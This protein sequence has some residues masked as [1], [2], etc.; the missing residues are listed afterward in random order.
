MK[1]TV[2]TLFL[3]AA[4]A[5]AFAQVQVDKPVL[6]EGATAADRRVIGLSN[7]VDEDDAL[8]ART[9]QAGGYR[10][11]EAV[12]SD[13]W[14]VQLDPPPSALT[15]GLKLLVKASVEN[16]GPVTIDVNSLGAHAVLK[17]GTAPLEAGDVLAGEV[18]TLVFDGTVFQLLGARRLERRPCPSGF[19]Q[20]NELYCIEQVERDSLTFY[21]ASLLCTGMNARLCSWGEW[22]AAC[23]DAASLGLTGMTG[24]W[25][26]TNDAANADYYVRVVG[27]FSCPHSGIAYGYSEERNYRCC[28]RR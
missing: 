8:N 5:S 17:N 1:H 19:T 13:D 21:Q 20:V 27:T 14:S 16:T 3:F 6:L 2:I 28:Y 7:A 15:A 25:E 12:G 18:A 11:A 22:Y 4:C 24:N 9:L 26:W 23:V 10:Y